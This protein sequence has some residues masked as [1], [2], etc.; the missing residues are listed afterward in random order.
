MYGELCHDIGM[1][2]PW[3]FVVAA[4]AAARITRLVTR[5]TITQPLRLWLINRAGVDT[6][7]AELIQCD[8]CSGVWVSSAVIGTTWAWGDHRWVQVCLTI[9]AAAHVVGYLA[10]WERD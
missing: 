9:L 8:W 10:T 1:I 3:L 6:R 7:L 5:D 2:S 4:L